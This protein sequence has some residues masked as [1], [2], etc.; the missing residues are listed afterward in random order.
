MHLHAD[1]LDNEEMMTKKLC[2]SGLPDTE[3]CTVA[4]EL[5]WLSEPSTSRRRSRGKICRATG[6]ESGPNRDERQSPWQARLGAPLLRSRAAIGTLALLRF[7][8]R[9]APRRAG[10][11]RGGEAKK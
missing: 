3:G 4:G 9:S 11:S 6:V 5:P 7:V 8:N 2:Q 10:F 1:G